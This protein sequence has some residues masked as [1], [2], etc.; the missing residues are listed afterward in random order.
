MTSTFYELG[1]S[2]GVYFWGEKEKTRHILVSRYIGPIYSSVRYLATYHK[3]YVTGSRFL[4]LDE[5]LT[6][7]HQLNLYDYNLY[8]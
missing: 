5:T 7:I 8:S 1:N 2:Y 4:S 6:Y 3:E